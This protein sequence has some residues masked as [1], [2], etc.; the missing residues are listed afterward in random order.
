[1]SRPVTVLVCLG[2]L[3]SLGCGTQATLLETDGE[4]FFVA[5][6]ALALPGEEVD[7][8]ARIQSGDLLEPRAGCVVLFRRDGEL[9]K[10]AETDDDGVAVVSFTPDT[11][12]L[13]RFTAEL[14]PNGFAEAPPPPQ[15]C[16]VACRTA[17]APMVI[18]DLDK[19]LVRSGFH[20]VLLGEPKPMPDSPRVMHR[21]AEKYSLV[22]LTH[23]PDYFGPKSKAWLAKHGYPLGPLLLSDIG[24]FL[25]GSAKFKSDVIQRLSKRFG[26]MR[27]GIGDKL[28]DA[29]SY[30]ANGMTAF[31]VLDIPDTV[32]AVQ[33]RAVADALDA[34]PK[35]V[36][37]VTSWRQI[38]QAVFDGKSF[39]P[40]VAQARLREMA[41]AREPEEKPEE[42]PKK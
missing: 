19:T 42:K 16:L 28:S 39:P 35:E 29:I 20:L 2:L 3:T 1:M 37:V 11:P 40:A 32:P 7:L 15:A 17:D 22:Y 9:F 21:L 4:N 26:N 6:D 41:Q 25:S 33:L 24:G 31:L 23:R 18:V 5:F 12:G 27:I 14:S 38:D 10:A 36:N 34:V 30:H 13:Y 8:R